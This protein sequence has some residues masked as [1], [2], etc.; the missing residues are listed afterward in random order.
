VSRLTDNITDFEP[1]RRSKL[2]GADGTGLEAV[3]ALG[4]KP[5]LCFRPSIQLQARSGV[6]TSTSSMKLQDCFDESPGPAKR[7]K[8][9]SQMP[10]R[11]PQQIFERTA[12]EQ[13]QH[14][15]QQDVKRGNC[16][17]E[18]SECSTVPKHLRLPHPHGVTTMPD[19]CV[20]A[21]ELVRT[22]QA[23]PFKTVA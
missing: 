5:Y 17:E 10:Y 16:K 1:V 7:Q 14:D 22:C 15:Q 21:R 2:V 19:W 8:M 6:S 11:A 20:H 3:R 23:L 4:D 13:Q 9:Q 12:Q 18:D